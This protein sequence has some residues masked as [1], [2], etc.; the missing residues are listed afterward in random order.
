[1]H[2]NS[3]TKNKQI[4]DIIEDSLDAMIADLLQILNLR[5]G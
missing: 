5:H 4:Q 1:M 2:N 3:I